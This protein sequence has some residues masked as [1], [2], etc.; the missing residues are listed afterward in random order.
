MDLNI[1]ILTLYCGELTI[2]DYLT[3]RVITSHGLR[4]NKNITYAMTVFFVPTEHTAQ[5]Q[6]RA[7]DENVEFW[8]SPVL[9]K[10]TTI[11]NSPNFVV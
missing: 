5:A 8:L 10:I 11:R 1:R 6:E 7:D 9:L 2:L 4:A 3:L